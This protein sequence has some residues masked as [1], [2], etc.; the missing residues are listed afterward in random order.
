MNKMMLEK[1]KRIM[2][3]RLN[4]MNKK[5]L[6]KEKRLMLKQM[7]QKIK[8][9]KILEKARRTMPVN[10]MQEPCKR[11]LST[12][13]SL[14]PPQTC[15]GL[16]GMLLHRDF[17]LSQLPM[18]CKLTQ[19]GMGIEEGWAEDEVDGAMDCLLVIVSDGSLIVAYHE[20]KRLRV[21]YT[22]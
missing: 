3:R 1:Q 22:V 13:D 4:K 16:P 5:M 8:K 7:K 17:H 15:L 20:Q 11:T 19:T 10:R 14:R 18:G 6:E 21:A 9:A 2:L 12:E